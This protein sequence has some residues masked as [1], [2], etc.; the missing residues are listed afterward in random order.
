MDIDQLRT[1][2]RIAREGS[3]TRAAARLNVTQATVSMRIRAL[4]DLLGGSLFERGRR[5]RLTERGM[6]F[7]P[8]ARRVLTAILEGEDALRSAERGRVAVGALRSLSISLI[9]DPLVRFTDGHPLVEFNIL[10]GHHR[11][12]AG[13]V[14]DRSIDLAIM[15]WPNLDPLL[16]EMKP[17]AIFRERVPLVASRRLAEAIGPEPTLERI[18]AAAPHFLLLGWWQVLPE[19][20]SA[21]RL[22]AR[23]ASNMPGEPALSLIRAGRGIGH[24]IET[25][26]RDELASGELVDLRPVD[27]PVLH[28]DSALVA[29]APGAL[30][31]PLVDDLAQAVVAHAR[32]LGILHEALR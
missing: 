29:A 3:F 21:L 20:L 24:Y 27:G 15:G 18:F 28:R 16:D 6:T 32:E 14:H 22:R 17:I 19:A 7:L 9:G 23:A 26:I 12:V 5:I 13:W 2:D 10:E 25:R 4:E 8:Y 30:D 11:D 1:F 31:R